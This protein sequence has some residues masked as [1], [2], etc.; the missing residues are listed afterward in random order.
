[1]ASSTDIH[2]VVEL[3]EESVENVMHFFESLAFHET[4]RKLN[5]KPDVLTKKA[6]ESE[7]LLL[8]EKLSNNKTSIYKKLGSAN[9][10][11]YLKD[12]RFKFG[13]LVQ[14][15]KLALM[16]ERIFN[17]AI[18]DCKFS[19]FISAFVREISPTRK[20]RWYASNQLLVSF[21]MFLMDKKVLVSQSNYAKY[22]AANF[23][24]ANG[25][26]IDPC[27]LAT[28]KSR[29]QDL[30][31][32]DRRLFMEFIKNIISIQRMDIEF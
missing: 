14:P 26:L 18:I 29:Y 20:I 25:D 9:E 22:I 2:S 15:D 23:L 6:L 31:I 32:D 12:E 24:D 10:T 4:I 11:D 3:I 27:G 17:T 19:I 8:I 13:L 21:I 28:A 5:L 16:H 30:K 1:M 7:K